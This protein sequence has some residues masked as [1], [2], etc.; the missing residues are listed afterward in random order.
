MDTREY[1]V[2]LLS[3]HL[4]GVKPKGERRGDW[5]QIYEFSERNN[6]TAIIAYEINL[7]AEDCRPK[8]EISEAFRK[9]L[10]RTKD[11]FDA[12][13]CSLAVFMSTLTN[14]G[15]PHLIIKGT[16]IRPHYP[17]PALRTGADI[18]V[19]VRPTD[20]MRAV[21]VLKERG[22]EEIRVESSEAQMR[23]S[24]DVFEIRTELEN[25]NIQSKIYFSTPFDDISEAMGCTYKLKP[26]YHLLYVITHIAHHLQAGGAGIKMIMDTDVLIRNYHEIDLD[27]FLTLCE[28]I[29][30]GKTASALIALAKKWFNTPAALNFTFED[31]DMNRLYSRLSKAIIGG[32]VFGAKNTGEESESKAK[33]FLFN[34]FRRASY[35]EPEEL[36]EAEKDIYDELG[37]E[38]KR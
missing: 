2:Y 24:Q 8:G 18:D 13:L 32:K 3:C 33:S 29:H 11:D 15:I 5:Q 26:I 36:T 30:I 35:G 31:R 25:I 12:R 14:A 27:E 1:F 10:D 16:S 17:V 7:L 34:L 21:E 22:L 37:L 38:P 4:N 20:Y 28:N 9:S 23:I 19:I 6:V